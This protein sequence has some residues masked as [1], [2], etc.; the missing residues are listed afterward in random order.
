[1][2]AQFEV[3]IAFQTDK[4][5]AEYE[6]LGEVVDGYAFDEQASKERTWVFRRRV[7]V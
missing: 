7:E 4:T 1:M 3:G 5:P 6:A 2:T